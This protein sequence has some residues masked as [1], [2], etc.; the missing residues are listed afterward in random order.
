MYIFKKTLYIIGIPIGSIYDFTQRAIFIL[1]NV[2]IIATEDSRK[3]GILLN[4]LNIKNKTVPLNS[5]NELSI[6][7]KLIEAIINNY[8]IAFISDSGTPLINDPGFYLIQLAYKNNI[9]VIPIP[10][11][12]SIT[13]ALS[14]SIIKSENLT[15]YGF[16]PKKQTQ[17]KSILTL[18]KNEIKNAIF[19]ETSDR[20]INTLLNIQHIL[21]PNR[22]ILIFKNLTKKFE[23]YF[24][25]DV[26]LIKKFINIINKNK[27]GEFVILINGT[28]K[29][30]SNNALCKKIYINKNNF[31]KHLL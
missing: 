31:F 7:K 8:S 2:N 6:S 23:M 21:Q 25:F 29:N 27:K 28:K 9:K 12:S 5:Y 3:S 20:I 18:I 30:Y 16:M 14:I 17:K 4:F 13:T 22:Q 26:I 15:F 24:F 11:I 1:K 10:G 19:F